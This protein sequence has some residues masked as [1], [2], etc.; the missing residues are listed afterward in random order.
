[1]FSYFILSSLFNIDE[2]L[3]EDLLY[4]IDLAKRDGCITNLIGSY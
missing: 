3:S 2:I 1:M 4:E